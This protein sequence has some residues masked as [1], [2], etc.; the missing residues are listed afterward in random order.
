MM[1]NANPS[2]AGS[3]DRIASEPPEK[4]QLP[5]IIFSVLLLILWV[6]LLSTAEHLVEPISAIFEWYELQLG[7]DI[8]PGNTE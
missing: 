5:A 2:D 8:L 4:S 7:L 1:L 3:K 6:V